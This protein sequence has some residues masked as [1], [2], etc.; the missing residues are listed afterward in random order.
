MRCKDSEFLDKEN[1]VVNKNAFYGQNNLCK[2]RIDKLDF[3]TLQSM[4]YKNL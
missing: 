3:H 4:K 1:E 2:V